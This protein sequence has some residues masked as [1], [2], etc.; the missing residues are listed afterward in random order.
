MTTERGAPMPEPLAPLDEPAPV[1][2]GEGLDLMALAEV[3]ERDVGL[4]G[5]LTVQQFP[6]GF[7][8][9][10][11]LVQAGEVEL[12]LRRPPAGASAR[13]GHD[14][15]REWRI[16]SAIHR[17]WPPV[18]RP[19]LFCDDVRVLG[20][21]F[22]VMERVRGTI[23]RGDTRPSHTLHAATMQALSTALID[24]LAEIHG[25]DWRAAG[26][27]DLAHPEGYVERQVSGWSARW[28]AA[29][30]DDVPA[31]EAVAVW[32]SANRPPEPGAD[33]ATL[34]HN[35]YKY[36]NLVLHP[37]GLA[38][39]VAV[40]D[41]EMATIGDP[42]LDL[43]TTLAYWVQPDD[44]PIFRALGLGI[45]SLP[46][47]LSREAL[48]SRYAER[49]GRDTTHMLFAYVHGLFKVAVIAQQIYKRFTLGHTT[50]ARFAMLGTAVRTLG[51]VA[52]D[53][54]ERGTITR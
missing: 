25:I 47:N 39:I 26:L 50:D 27:D 23:L 54:L 22:F 8:N 17:L 3:L 45:T 5:T 52:G 36:D 10:T 30:T 48:V 31:L 11:Y 46:G 40:L 9:L 34:V 33:G 21:P 1:R 38:R 37:E 49:T 53:A 20:V 51:E 13:G 7:S 24:G 15:M 14:M 12:V 35:D 18:P 28:D 43:G 44:P 42:L 41:W 6:R 16:L 32:L 19:V 29:R 2:A 4:T